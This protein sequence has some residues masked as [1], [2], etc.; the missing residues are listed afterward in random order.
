MKKKVVSKESFGS[1]DISED[2]N[3]K[4]STDQNFATVLYGGGGGYLTITSPE[5]AFHDELA[6]IAEESMPCLWVP[7]S[8][9]LGYI[10]VL[11]RVCITLYCMY[12]GLLDMLQT[13]RSRN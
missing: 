1:L 12:T 6:S 8:F 9:L 13:P 2:R 7:S 11:P 10:S 5:N 3:M 4:V